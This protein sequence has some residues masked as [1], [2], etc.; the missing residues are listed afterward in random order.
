MDGKELNLFCI[1]T[2][3]CHS[4][5]ESITPRVN[6]ALAREIVVVDCCKYY[7]LNIINVVIIVKTI[8]DHEYK[9]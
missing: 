7:V 9:L 6:V 8:H 4:C 5:Q 3:A 2:S 1:L